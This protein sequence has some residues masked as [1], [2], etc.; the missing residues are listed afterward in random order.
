MLVL[1]VTPPA[2]ATTRPRIGDVQR[3]LEVLAEDAGIVGVIGEAFYDGK[4]IGRGSAGSRLLGGKGGK[5]PSNAR[6]RIG[7]ETKRMTATAL[8]Q[9]VKAR[10][11][12]VD[13]KL[14]E[15]LPVVAERDLVERANEITI[16][17]LIDHTSG[18]P[19]YAG[20]PGLEPWDVTTHHSPIDL[21][22]VS[23]S[24]ARQQD[25][26]EKFAYSNINYILLGMIIEKLTGNT[27][28]EEFERRFFEPLGMDRTYL[29]TEPGQ[30]IKGPHGHGYLAQPDGSVR[31][32]D[33]QNATSLWA[34]GGVI[35]TAEDMTDFHRAFAQG[36][37]LP[38]NLRQV[39]TGNQRPALCGG[40]VDGARG[41]G[42]GS[43]SMTFTS[44]DGRLQLAVSATTSVKDPGGT[45]TAPIQ[46]AAEAVLCPK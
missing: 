33:R 39:I 37:L 22:K 3:A 2:G 41:V 13:D 18:I 14:S 26:G 32:I 29:P 44:A 36:R 21:L 42:L 4:R 31:D 8:L 27:L 28:A 46:R 10:K 34:A 15:V 43:I 38:A 11:L 45:F 5:I 20:R 17:Q 1:S 30:G 19:D 12:G 16:R 35:S 9:L 25:P 24:Q 6:Y 7:S 23:R 40:K